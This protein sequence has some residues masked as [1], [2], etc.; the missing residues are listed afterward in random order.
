MLI[1]H[2]IGKLEKLLTICFNHFKKRLFSEIAKQNHIKG[3]EKK[4]ICAIVA[5]STYKKT[6]NTF[7]KPISELD[8]L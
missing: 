5:N 2:I 4:V 6:Y 1:L 7:C 3:A 8:K